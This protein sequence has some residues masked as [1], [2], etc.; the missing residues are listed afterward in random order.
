M[1][2]WA[3]ETHTP[4]NVLQLNLKGQCE[5]VGA[6]NSQKSRCEC[7]FQTDAILKIL[8]LISNLLGQIHTLGYLQGSNKTRV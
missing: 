4:N 7:S 3:S 2:E 1:S 8:R 5:N 6:L